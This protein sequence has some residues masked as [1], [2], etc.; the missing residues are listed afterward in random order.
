MAI[1]YWP[2]H[3][4][5]TTIGN[6]L[7]VAT[8]SAAAF[9]PASGTLIAALLIFGPRC[10]PWLLGS[11]FIAEALAY[12]PLQHVF[13]TQVGLQI[14]LVNA[15]QSL[16]AVLLIRRYI[17]Q[18]IDF[19][20]VGPTARLTAALLVAMFI[21]SLVGGVV[22]AGVGNVAPYWR[23]QQ[24]WW[25][26]GYLGAIVLVPLILSWVE[27][28]FRPAH[29]RVQPARWYLLLQFAVLALVVWHVFSGTH[30][31]DLIALDSPFFVYSILL[32]IASSGGARRVTLALLLVSVVATIYT[33]AGAGPYGSAS[34][35]P[36]S[37][38]LNLQAFLVLV[39]VPLL[40]V[41]AS[42]A[43][44]RGALALVRASDERYR[45]FVAHSSEAIF[46]YELS[47]PMPLSLPTHEQHAWLEAHAYIA[48]ANDAFR[49]ADGGDLTEALV[50]RSPSWLKRCLATVPD[51]IAAGGR[52]E[53]VECVLP[54][55]YGLDRTLLVS[56]STEVSHG[57][58][59]RIWGVARDV[60]QYRSAQRRLEE[61]QREL[62]ALATELTLTED[63]ARRK[64]AAD[65]H[66]GLAQSLVGLQMH[67]AAIRTAAEQGRPLPDVSTLELTISESTAQVRALMTDLTP[68]G[69]HDQGIVTGMSWLADEFAK[70]Q[71]VR[72]DF[73]DDGVP[74]PLAEATAVLV[75][76]AARQLL[77][78]V[79][80]HAQSTTVTIRTT[81]TGGR[82]ELAV[83]DSGVGFNVSDLTFLPTRQGGFGLYSIR[84]RLSIIGGTL[85]IDST[86]GRGTRVRITAPLASADSR[87]QS[88]TGEPVRRAVDPGSA[89]C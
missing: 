74:K 9:W 43:E 40:V 51:T 34:G 8:S 47:Q 46:R 29:D 87:T 61:Q 32:W 38:V 20:R 59:Q 18:R 45:A 70:R 10:W 39:V 12:A 25:M 73:G 52:V 66:D 48:E 28:G 78:N 14:A 36:F 22:V 42:I 30:R 15:G 60:T 35:S 81:V 80:R 19:A 89:A 53:N 71:R 44:K 55:P 54:G 23:N 64:I 5:A 37:P 88:A 67:V 65:L 27:W 76:Q 4:A 68:P 62:R 1:G 86:P 3:L 69:L 11:A 31:L 21:G 85:E 49:D 26:S 17:G 7:L 58:L 57:A 24:A 16:L 63:R 84:E 75:F 82:F 72:V 79:A 77:Q 2:I 33:L 56:L 83:S 13:A 41:Q 6:S 50:A